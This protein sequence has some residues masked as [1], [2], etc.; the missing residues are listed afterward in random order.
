M[1]KG[2]VLAK[3]AKGLDEIKARTHGLPQK[4]RSILIMVDGN[5]TAGDLI[6]KCGGVPEV[7]AALD[8]FVKDGFVEIKGRAAAAPPAAPAAPPSVAPKVAGPATQP[9]T[10]AQALSALTRFLHDNLGPDADLVTGNLER[11]ALRADFTAAAE[12]CAD[13]LAAIRGQAKA[14][15]FRDRAKSFADLYLAA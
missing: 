4:L 12:R 7:E 15:A 13:M 5:A 10:R 11:A 3:T 6:G 8:G 1:D 9:Q 14:Q 2:A